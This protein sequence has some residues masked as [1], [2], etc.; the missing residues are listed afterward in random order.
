LTNRAIKNPIN[1]LG[2]GD[3]QLLMDPSILAPAAEILQTILSK[4]QVFVNEI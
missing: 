3:N 1:Y 4:I 2:R